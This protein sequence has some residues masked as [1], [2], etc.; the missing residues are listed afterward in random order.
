MLVICNPVTEEL[1]ALMRIDAQGEGGEATLAVISE[2]DSHA[3]EPPAP[4]AAAM[5]AADVVVAPTIQSLSHTDSAPRRHRSR[6]ADRHDARRHRRDAGPGDGRRHDELLRKRGAAVGRG[7]RRRRGGA[8]HLRARLRPAARARGPDR[9]RRRRR[10]QRARRLRQPA[11]R[12]GLHRAARGDGGG[13]A[14]R[15]RLDRRRRQGR[16]AGRA[17]RSRRSPDRRD[18]RRGRAR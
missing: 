8:D 2:R 12:R 13:N 16:R 11:L 5:L 14:R 3:A 1:G 10:A 9:D 4:V 7:A 6:R 18:R 15:R 17:H